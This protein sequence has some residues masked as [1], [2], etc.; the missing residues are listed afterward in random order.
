M[1]KKIV[2]L[3]SILLMFPLLSGCYYYKSETTEIYH[4]KDYL[5]HD[6]GI[7]IWTISEN[8]EENGFFVSKEN[9]YPCE[10]SS[11]VIGIYYVYE[12]AFDFNDVFTDL[13]TVYLYLNKKE[14]EEYLKEIYEL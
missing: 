10:E 4:V 1:K 2:V 9:V 12:N 7:E 14:F 3:I 8:G 13:E 6:T 11:R 5:I